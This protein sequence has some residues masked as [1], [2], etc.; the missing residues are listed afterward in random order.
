MTSRLEMVQR[1][2]FEFGVLT[3]LLGM[4]AT[5]LAADGSAVISGVVR[6]AKGVPQMGALVQILAP[7]DAVRA[8]AF[9]DMKGRYLVA[10]LLPGLYGI[11]ASAALFLPVSREHLRLQPD[12]RAIVNLTLSGLFDEPAWLPAKAKGA[13]EPTDDWD[14]TLRSSANR[15]ILKLA[16]DDSSA[17][18]TTPDRRS[19]ADIHLVRATLTS[20]SNNFGDGAARVNVRAER[21]RANRSRVTLSTFAGAGKTA[22][23]SAAPLGV[24]SAFERKTGSAGVLGGR[25]TYESHPEISGARGGN[26]GPGIRVFAVSSAERFAVGEFAEIEAGSRVQ[27]IHGATSAVVAR[28]FLRVSAHSGNSWRVTYSVATSRDTQDYDSAVLRD[29]DLP[30]AINVGGRIEAEG[31]VHQE[32]ALSHESNATLVALAVYADAMDRVSLLGGGDPFHENPSFRDPA[33]GPSEILFDQSNGSFKALGQGYRNAGLNVLITRAFGSGAWVTLQYCS[34]TAMAPTEVHRSAAAG[35]LPAL[36]ARR[37]QAVTASVKASIARTGT[38]VRTSY[39]WQ[40]DLLVTSIDP[41]D[42]LAGG[43]F[44]SLHLRQPFNLRGI[45]PEGAELTVDGTNML[46]QGRLRFV[47]RNGNPLYLASTPASLQAGIAFNF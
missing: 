45:L 13:A 3:L 18:A 15:P 39:R 1:F 16:D 29:A 30:T 35:G 25:I 44:L 26:G 2:R 8:T 5:G 21:V 23:T 36:Q 9:T 19:G 7:D 38:K 37:S 20:G 32:V 14:W 40:P 31:G 27:A 47:G 17:G 34:G 33:S 46:G 28:P 24:A 10:R 12:R 11:R 42:M 6:D 4:S 22:R 43:E 41:Y